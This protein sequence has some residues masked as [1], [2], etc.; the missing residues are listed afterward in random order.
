[1]TT[2]RDHT[3]RLAAEFP[4]GSDE[5]AAL[6]RLAA[7]RTIPPIVIK[8]VGEGR[9][10]NNNYFKML[11]NARD[12]MEAASTQIGQVATQALVLDRFS[13][14]PE[15]KDDPF[16]GPDVKWDTAEKTFTALANQAYSLYKILQKRA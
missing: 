2:L 15:A 4:T 6:Y 10:V 5:Q 9:R 8:M 13:Q 7:T 11:R 16:V 1:M 12:L 14:K 3:L